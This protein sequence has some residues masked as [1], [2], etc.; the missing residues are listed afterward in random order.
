MAS[1]I[2]PATQIGLVTLS[3][4]DLPRSLAYYQASIGLAVLARDGATATLGVGDTPLL[5]LHELPG[6][7]VVRR[8]TGLYH[9]ALRV[10]PGA[11]WRASWSISG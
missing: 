3:V 4:G 6:A 7:R 9:F 1:I 10:R 5:R 11:T 8:A 2:D